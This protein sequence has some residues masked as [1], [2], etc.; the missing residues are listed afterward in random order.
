MILLSLNKLSLYEFRQCVYYKSFN[1]GKHVLLLLYI[2][3]ML[4]ARSS[5]VEINKL[6]QQLAMIFSMKDLSVA[7]KILQNK[8]DQKQEEKRIKTITW[9]IYLKYVE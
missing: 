9:N 5:I 2:D 4:V 6:K 3:D 1:N 8:N 7:K